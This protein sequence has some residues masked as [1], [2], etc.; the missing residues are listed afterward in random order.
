MAALALYMVVLYLA[1]GANLALAVYAWTRRAWGARTFAFLLI[2]CAWYSFGYSMEL[3]SATLEGKQDWLRFQNVAIPFLAPAWMLVSLHYTGY[4]SKM[5]RFGP[6][7][8]FLIPFGILALISTNSTHH[9]YYTRQYLDATGPFPVML[10]EKGPSYWVN[11][12]YIN[13]CVAAGIA[14][15]IHRSRSSGIGLRR[16]DGVMLLGSAFPW[17]GHVVYQTGV[18]LRGIDF[19]PL[20]LG[21][22][23]LFFAYGLS[24][25]Y[26]LDLTRVAYRTVFE[27]LPDAILVIDTS[28]RLVDFNPAALRL[29]P[30]LSGHLGRPGF[31]DSLGQAPELASAIGR[32]SDSSDAPASAQ[33][34]LEAAGSTT[35]H[36]LR[37]TPIRQGGGPAAGWILRLADVSDQV[38]AFRQLEELARI[39][40]L[41]GVA[42]R[43]HLMDR[44]HQ[45]LARAR[46]Y[47]HPLSLVIMDLDH[48]KRINDTLGHPVGD[49]VLKRFASVCTSSL[50]SV[51]VF[52]R[53]GGEEFAALLPETDKAGAATV[54]GRLCARIAQEW[55]MEESGVRSLTAS[56]GVATL[57]PGDDTTP[58]NIDS[59]VAQADAAL[60]RAKAA[61]RNGVAVA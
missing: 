37:I 42:N 56:F 55:L 40:G 47:G 1:A 18:G 41:T 58:Q 4:L 54:A 29:L 36:E 26:L 21:I 3:G 28:H 43:R 60:Y 32:L 48:F 13:V 8:L 45:E 15:V 23:G 7:A 11:V 24:R 30:G 9:L 53:V 19:T 44:A 59:L 2:V 38:R 27:G 33:V 6:M 16:S 52:G 22:S 49:Q 57:I 25:R 20:A 51:D 5:G 31:P 14:L 39:D 10:L 35:H 46:R 50:R 61:G 34:S 12:A 17:A